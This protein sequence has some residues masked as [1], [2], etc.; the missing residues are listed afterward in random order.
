MY[1]EAY[2]Y[3]R[4]HLGIFEEGGCPLRIECALGEL[5]QICIHR[6]CYWSGM[7][8]SPAG[9]F[10]NKFRTFLGLLI[11]TCSWVTKWCS[12]MICR[13]QIVCKDRNAPG[14]SVEEFFS[15]R[16]RQIQ[17]EA[18]KFICVLTKRSA[19]PGHPYDS[20]WVFPRRDR[21]RLCGRTL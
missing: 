2:G 16:K 11:M 20:M 1:R 7:W 19:S 17:T 21:T 13:P 8:V 5:T 4:D 18:Q 3:C 10:W 6:C 9:H 12:V 14:L 15:S